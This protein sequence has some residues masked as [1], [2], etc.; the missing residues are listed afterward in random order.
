ME[1]FE[2]IKN[3][4]LTLAAIP[5]LEWIHFATLLSIKKI[6]KGEIYFHQ[7]ESFD[8]IGFVV[9]GLMH[10]YYSLPNDEIAVN[11]FIHEGMPV[12]C[13]ADQLLKKPASFSCKAIEDTTLVNIKFK[14][15][16]KLYNRHTC[17]EKIGRLSAEK[18]YIEKE[19]RE[20]DFLM[21]DA[22]QRYEN[23]VNTNPKIINRVPQ[24]LI[25]S[26]LG[27]KPESLSRIRASK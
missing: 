13:Y 22:K 7:G 14:D 19:I 8:Q 27:I 5:P 25:A 3:H 20:R 12:T 17:W 10:N 21:M 4:L 15:F 16:E 18:L 26:Y 11:Y 24:Y 1:F 23:F 2:N 6:K 9:S